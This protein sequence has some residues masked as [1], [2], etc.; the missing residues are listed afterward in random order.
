MGFEGMG[1]CVPLEIGFALNF[2]TLIGVALMFPIQRK[3]LQIFEDEVMK[4]ST[5][6]AI[7]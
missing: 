1:V 4:N 5:P 2:F 7:H 3:S 6:L